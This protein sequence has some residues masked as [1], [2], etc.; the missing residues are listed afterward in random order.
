MAN[1]IPGQTSS[2]VTETNSAPPK[3]LPDTN[4]KPLNNEPGQKITENDPSIDGSTNNQTVSWTASEFINHEK[5]FGWYAILSLVTVFIATL[6]YFITK[7]KISTFVIVIAGG[8]MAFYANRKPRVLNYQLDGM[9][10]TVGQKYYEYDSFKAFSIIDEDAF[11]SIVFMPLKRF[12]PSLT[13]YYSPSDEGRI[14]SLLTDRLPH[15][16]PSNDVVD[17]LMRKIRF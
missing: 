4:N 15:E 7:D 17:G 8:V 3:E 9:G 1:F 10:V 16:D 14:V 12:S 13:I 6:T 11:S 2:P 5:S